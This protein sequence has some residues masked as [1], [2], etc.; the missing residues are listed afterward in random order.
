MA[1]IP[2]LAELH[3]PDSAG[4]G[5][6]RTLL[7][8][9][10]ATLREAFAAL[11]SPPW[12]AYVRMNDELGIVHAVIPIP[13]ESPNDGWEMLSIRGEV[14]AIIT[15]CDYRNARR[16][17]V[18]SEPFIEAH[19]SM[20]GAT[21]L[22]DDTHA[23]VA[24]R[25][26]NMMVCRQGVDTNYLVYCPPGPRLHVSLYVSPRAMTG[27][28]GLEATERDCGPNPFLVDAAPATIMR[29]LPIQPDVQAALRQLVKNDFAGVRRTSFVGSKIIE[30]ACFCARDITA[31]QGKAG[32]SF[33]FSDRDLAIFER[34]RELLST[35]FNPPLTI[36]A[37]AKTIGTN[38]NK[39]KAGFKL[40]YGATV[41]EFAN[42]H[43]M[44]HAMVLLMS[45]HVPISEV[46]ST[47]GYRS[48][49]SFSTAFKAFFG[50]L[51]REVRRTGSVER[52]QRAHQTGE[53]EIRA[54]G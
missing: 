5:L 37:L 36:P 1:D 6:F 40:I 18:P 12:N 50:R 31:F 32:D 14:F 9:E 20:E 16:E 11:L 46:A 30:L 33:T 49:A 23:D 39:L 38:T 21:R 22:V 10:G 24:I 17:I 42:Q 7:G 43:R 41:F 25:C 29:Q 4:Y 53:G 8:G 52:T 27:Q 15:K 45:R 34:A 19:F 54:G 48:Q 13:G 2:S 35:Q 26:D 3:N 44:Q 28:F 47:V 51:P